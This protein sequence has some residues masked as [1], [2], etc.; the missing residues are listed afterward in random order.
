MCVWPVNDLLVLHTCPTHSVA[1][2]MKHLTRDTKLMGQQDLETSFD[3]CVCRYVLRLCMLE[4]REEAAHYEL[5]V[6]PSFCMSVVIFIPVQQY[7]AGLTCIP[8]LLFELC[9]CR[10]SQAV[11]Y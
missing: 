6:R 3:V 1:Y 10:H 8:A 5:R 9:S 2:G 4:T 11:S 7:T